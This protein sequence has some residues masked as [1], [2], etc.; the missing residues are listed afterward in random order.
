MLLVPKCEE[1][2]FVVH[3]CSVVLLN[4]LSFTSTK[5]QEYKYW[6]QKRL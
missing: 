6:R 5:V 1:E 3:M 2:G 4:L